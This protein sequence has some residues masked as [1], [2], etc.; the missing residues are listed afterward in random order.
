MQVIFGSLLG[1]WRNKEIPLVIK[2]IFGN[3]LTFDNATV[4]RV[5][6]DSFVLVGDK[7]S[8]KLNDKNVIDYFMQFIK[9]PKYR[10][11][12]LKTLHGLDNVT[13]I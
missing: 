9:Y 11:Y 12:I 6:K 1:S 13:E 8:G 3:K 10:K 5:G 7:K 4:K 2:D